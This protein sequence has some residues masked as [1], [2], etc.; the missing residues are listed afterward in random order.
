MPTTSRATAGHATVGRATSRDRQGR[1]VHLG[2]GAFARAFVLPATAAAG[3]WG[4]TA[5]TGRSARLADALN[6]QDG[7]YGLIVRGS[8]GDDV[9]IIDVIDETLPAADVDALD[10]VIADPLTAVVTLTITEKGYSAGTAPETSAPARLARALRARREAG[11]D[12]PIAL[13]SCDNLTG[14]GAVLRDAV[15]A[16]AD[17]AIRD[18]FDAHVDVIS[19]MVDRITPV[20]GEDEAQVVAEHTGLVDA[21][22]VVTEPFWEW[23]IEDS[24][25][26]RRP[27]WEKV[28]AQLVAD[29]SIHEERKLRLL[30]GA[31]SLL[32]YAGSLAGH[33]RV[34]E[35]I[36]DHEVRAL[37]EALWAEASSTLDL[38]A[39]DL[40]AYTR[41]LEE[42]FRNP[43]LAD[44]L[45]RI[46]ADGSEKL[47]VRTLPVIAER[48]GPS[49]APAAVAV[50]AAWTAWVTQRVR[51]GHE[52]ADPRADA[53][54]EAA[55]ID[56]D[57]ER[58]AAL[59]AQLGVQDDP[60]LV[61]AVTAEE[62]RLP[63]QARSASVS[64]RSSRDL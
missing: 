25:R 50:L 52:I 4:V 63:R 13:V 38:P 32:A 9:E 17:P 19:T 15:L 3:G 23:V 48:G 64:N 49:E 31:H 18:W 46:A 2:I 35:A 28:G 27:A 22:P 60:Q 21:A 6:A 1:L 55:R 43:R 41:A 53:L 20:A 11:V 62:G 61:A 24:F 16:A 29:V 33:D 30:N 7:R 36:S 47:R 40:A 56:F 39:D 57:R 26:G 37:V 12:E 58:V 51:D 5:V 8:D 10:Q 34:D 14:N 44:A 59:L 45:L 54:A 42:R